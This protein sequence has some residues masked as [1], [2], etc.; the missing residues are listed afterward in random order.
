VKTSEMIAMLE[1]NPELK[2]KSQNGYRASVNEYTG[3]FIWERYSGTSGINN[4]LRLL[5]SKAAGFKPDNWTVIR[6]P[7]PWQEAIQAWIDGKCI[8]AE[9]EGLRKLEI[10]PELRLGEFVHSDTGIDLIYF[11]KGTWYIGEACK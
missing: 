10:N 8:Y 1:K 7:V 3:L 11:Q 4:N 2:F 6:E 5:P 9:T